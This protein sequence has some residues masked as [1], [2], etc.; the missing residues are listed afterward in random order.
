MN[1]KVFSLF[2]IAETLMPLI[3]APLYSRVYI[4]TLKTLPGTFMLF[5]VAAT[6]P[7]LIIFGWFYKQHKKDQKN[8][9]LEVPTVTPATGETPVLP[10]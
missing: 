2:G 3:F 9:R 8:K 5:S 6:I 1:G 10:A 7:A 4:A